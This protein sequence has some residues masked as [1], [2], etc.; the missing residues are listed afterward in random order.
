MVDGINGVFLISISTL[1]CGGVGLLIKLLYKL[2]CS[3]V[4]CC[5]DCIVV[6]RD[7]LEEIKVD[8]EAQESTASNTRR[9]SRTLGFA[10]I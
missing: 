2:K 6:K 8:M 9:S 10:R 5:F 1:F 7:V 4:A 3:E